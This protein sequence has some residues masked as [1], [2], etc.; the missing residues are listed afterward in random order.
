MIAIQKNI[1]MVKTS[2]NEIQAKQSHLTCSASF[3][4]LGLE[5]VTVNW[6]KLTS[7]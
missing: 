6:R 1:E 3:N 4:F 5:F 2:I 7:F